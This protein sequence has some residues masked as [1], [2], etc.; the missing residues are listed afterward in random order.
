ML[1]TGVEIKITFVHK[2]TKISIFKHFVLKN[3]FFV[4][5]RFI[6]IIA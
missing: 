6:K 5:I 2:N 4:F 3:N 1:Y